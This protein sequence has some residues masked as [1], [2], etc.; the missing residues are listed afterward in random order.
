MRTQIPS[1]DD[2]SRHRIRVGFFRYLLRGARLI[3]PV[4]SVLAGFMVALGIAVAHA[5]GWKLFDGV[6]FAF[7][8]GL[9]VG[10]G[11]LVPTRLISRIAAIAIGLTGILL[12][13]LLAAVSVQA[14]QQAFADEK[15]RF[16]AAHTKDEGT[17]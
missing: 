4:L 10:Y 9:T 3:L 17:T 5:E 16:N 14:L 8:T 1:L 13:G 12:T 2:H 7:V 11:D 6:Y 15:A